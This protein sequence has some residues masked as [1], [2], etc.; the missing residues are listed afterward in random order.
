MKLEG[1][2]GELLT[3]LQRG[4]KPVVRP[5]AEAEARAGAAAGSALALL[6][7]LRGEGVVRRFGGVF[8]A[9]RL[10]YRSCLCAMAVPP[11][12]LESVAEVVCREP[13]VTHGYERLAGVG[14]PNF[15]FTLAEQGELF[16][17][18]LARLRQ[19]VSP[20]EVVVLPAVERYKIDVV[21]DVGTR[22][23]DERVEPPAV[24]AGE[25]GAC[26]LSLEEKKLVRLLE[27]DLGSSEEP[28][29]A[30]ARA[31][32]W[33]VERVLERAQEWLDAGVLR[34]IGVLIKH[35]AAGFTANGMCCWDVPEG[36]M[37]EF[38]RRLAQFRE[39][40][41]CY[42]RP[43]SELVPFRLYAMIHTGSS[44]ETRALCAR[45]SREAGLPAG[46]VFLS[47]RE[48]KKTSMAFFPEVK[49]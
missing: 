14:R 48:F 13:G 16:E 40:T 47:A 27:G 20:F 21:F 22:E 26:T 32:R 7:R 8:D 25:P 17:R 41:H 29:A 49:V 3:V 6:G 10:G 4:V 34:R 46:E 15:W 2:E 35:R 42:A 9:R 31:M 11:G 28:F 12:V 36:E 44:E 24:L 37:R 1:G 33:P 45:L 23:R 30:V 43:W 39:V 18:T 38:G 19:E 5:F